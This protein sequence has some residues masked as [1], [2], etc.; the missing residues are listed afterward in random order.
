MT[1]LKQEFEENEFVVCPGMFSETEADGFNMTSPC[2]PPFWHPHANQDAL[3]AAID[4]A[5]RS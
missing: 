2:T 5:M 4:F 3:R 1:D